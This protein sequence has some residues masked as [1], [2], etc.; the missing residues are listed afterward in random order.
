MLFKYSIVQI[1][2]ALFRVLKTVGETLNFMFFCLGRPISIDN[3]NIVIKTF[4]LTVN[5][6]FS[7]FY[8]YFITR[9]GSILFLI[10]FFVA[11]RNYFV[12]FYIRV[13]SQELY[14]ITTFTF[15]R[16]KIISEI[17]KII[18]KTC[19]V[20]FLLTYPIV[21]NSLITTNAPSYTEDDIS[22]LS[23]Y[24]KWC[25]VLVPLVFIELL[26]YLWNSKCETPFCLASVWN[27]LIILFY[28]NSWNSNGINLKN[29]LK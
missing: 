27:F 29:N 1:V 17:L 13:A 24:G 16:K 2:L 8:L 15:P 10:F 23:S 19:S 3:L 5:C 26:K 18:L 9:L 20:V 14:G 12:N 22:S 4:V 11:E 6:I 28:A 25:F 7:N 21:L